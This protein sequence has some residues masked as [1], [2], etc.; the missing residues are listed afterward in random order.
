MDREPATEQDSERQRC[1]SGGIT[2]Y[3]WIGSLLD[4]AAKEPEVMKTL[5]ETAFAADKEMVAPM[6][7]WR[8]NGQ[9]AGN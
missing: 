4:A 9:P 3:R 2:V 7:E 5:Q 6:M 8:Y 1:P